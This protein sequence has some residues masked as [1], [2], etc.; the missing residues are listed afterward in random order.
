MRQV[1]ERYL[2]VVEERRLLAHVAQFADLQARRDH[3]W[4]R[5][6]RQTGVRVQAFSRLTVGDA[7]EALA[8]GYLTLP[9]AI[10]KGGQGHRVFLTRKAQ[11]ALRDLLRLRREQGHAEQADSPL[12]MSRHARGLSVRSFQARMRHWCQAAGLRVAA[13]P[14][15]FRHTL[16]KRL[17]AA[18]T[19]QDPA[20]VVQGVL[21]HRSRSSTGVYLMADREVM[22]QAMEAA[23]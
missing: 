17:V 19:A 2:T 15:W 5:A 8:S 13:S 6:L 20:A 7:R 21:G 11:A 23:S 22:E 18:S 14:H 1:F 3:A 4:M 12:V 9:A 10:Q 16:A